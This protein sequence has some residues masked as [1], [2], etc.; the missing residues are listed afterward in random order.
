MTIKPKTIEEYLATLSADHRAA[1]EKLLKTIRA[2]A[3]KAEECISYQLPAFRQNRMLV[4]FG[5]TAKHCALYLMSSSTAEA[6]K[7]ELKGYGTSKGTIRFP[8][9]KPLS[10][11][12]ERKLVKAWIA[13]NEAMDKTQG[14]FA[15]PSDERPPQ[16]RSGDRK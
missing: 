1:L 8:A 15:H 7:D 14:R 5:A 12:L 10:A 4:A 16:P 13:E 2:P 9:D 11:V 6:H 3:P